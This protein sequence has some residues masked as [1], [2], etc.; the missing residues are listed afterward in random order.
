MEENFE[1]QAR[2]RKAKETRAKEKEL[3]DKKLKTK[4]RDQVFSTFDDVKKQRQ[5]E[6]EIANVMN[7]YLAKE[8]INAV[9]QKNDK[10]LNKIFKYFCKQQKLETELDV[11]F[12]LENM[13][14]KQFTKF[15]Y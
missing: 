11:N 14:A 3:L 4:S 2:Q 7:D 12:V 5:K 13:N 15:A 9:L 10:G 1:R 6:Q 8:D